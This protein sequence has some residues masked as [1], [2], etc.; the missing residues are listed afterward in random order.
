MTPIIHPTFTKNNQLRIDISNNDLSHGEFKL[1]FSLVYSIISIDGA[2]ISKQVGRY[3][4]LHTLQNSIHLNLQKPRIGSYN[5]SCGPEGIF[6]IT[7]ENKYREVELLSLK[8]EKEI[9][10]IKYEKVEEKNFIPIIPEP[11][12][13]LLNEQYIELIDLKIQI[14]SKDLEIFKILNVYTKPLD[15]KFNLNE[16]IQLIFLNKDSKD[17]EYIIKIKSE[18]IEIYYSNY[19]GKLYALITLIQLIHYYKNK[20]PLCIIEDSP[21]LEWRGM[22]L[23]CARQYYSIDEIKRLFNYMAL[24]KLNRF[25]WHLTD[26]EAWR[27]QL[28]CYPNLTNIGAFRG[29]NQLIAPFYGSGF[30][31]YGGYYSKDDVSE[32]IE[33]GKKL[34]IEI[35]PEIDLPA[36]SWTLLQI[37]PE[38]R[39]P[40]SNAETKDVGS[41]SNNTINPSVEETSIFLENVFKELSN[42]FTFDIIH[43]GVDERPKES[44]EG[45][46]K[47]I[48]FMKKNNLTSYDEVQDLYMNN[49]ITT[50]KKH[51]K[52]TAAWNEAALSPHNDIGSSGSAGN[53]D[54]SCLVF[55]WE[56]PDVGKEAAKRGFDTILCPGHKTYFDMA[57][58]NSTHERGICWAATI[59]AK[60]VHEWKPMESID[61]DKRKYVKG[62]QGQMWSETITKKEYFDS[63]INPRLATLSEIAWRSKSF[64]TWKEFQPSLSICVDLLT[65]IGW[66]FHKF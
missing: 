15:I 6:I 22:H 62:I 18:K 46:P 4:E 49:I 16:G 13:Y 33:Y 44:W 10:N 26:N 54:K 9:N 43:V 7:K 25:H 20:L 55:A 53:I 58:N 11:K 8:F 28:D 61:T 29:Y 36:H 65:K 52:R 42:I 63:M 59:E 50:L 56:H 19:A 48:E 39:D 17:D 30:H 38:L 31:K 45:S 32:L 21:S 27:I 47:I 57:Y 24:F 37:M 1:C 34:N 3:Y 2:E 66:K 51:N 23:D 40:S 41:Y 35:M 5:L 14:N 64:R 12:K 60:E